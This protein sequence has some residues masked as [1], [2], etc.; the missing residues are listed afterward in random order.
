MSILSQEDLR[1][2][3]KLTAPDMHTIAQV[4]HGYVGVYSALT[5]AL[6][7]ID[8]LTNR[9]VFTVYD[10]IIVTQPDNNLPDPDTTIT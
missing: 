6:D 2:L 4:G 9:L 10:P 3:R 1:Q 5:L 8:Y 7:H